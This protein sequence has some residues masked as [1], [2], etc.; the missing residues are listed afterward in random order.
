MKVIL[1]E[2]VP[3][4]G[5]KGEV[6]NVAD[7]YARNYLIPRNLAVEATPARMKEIEKQQKIQEKKEQKEIAAAQE[8]ARE[9]E[10][11]TFIFKVQ[12]SEEGRLFGSVTSADIAE[13]MKE[14]GVDLDKR[15][16]ELEDPIKEL[17]EFQIPIKFK[18]G[19]ETH[20]QIQVTKED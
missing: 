5:N 13:A 15:K 2:E 1:T 7:G 18:G 16:I 6:K 8:Q 3:N 20:I 10:G 11:K 9:L 17:G 4:L 12:A 19:I 14:E